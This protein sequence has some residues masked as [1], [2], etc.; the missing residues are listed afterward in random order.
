MW[1]TIHTSTMIHWQVHQTWQ[2]SRTRMHPTWL[3]MQIRSR[4]TSLIVQ[5]YAST[6]I[7]CNHKK[8]PLMAWIA[9]CGTFK[10]RVMMCGAALSTSRIKLTTSRSAYHAQSNSDT[11]EGQPILE[12]PSSVI[13]PQ[14]MDTWRYCIIRLEEARDAWR[15]R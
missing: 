12:I 4:T 6:R 7:V 9:S 3:I 13:H 8:N 2:I 5:A 1:Q 14:V 11:S 15:K 10:P